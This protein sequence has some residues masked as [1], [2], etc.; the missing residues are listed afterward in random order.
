[1]QFLLKL[2]KALNSAQTPWQVTFAIT[3]GMVVGLTPLSGIQTVVIFFLAF[4]LNIHLGLF[5]ASSAFFA[6]IGY[7]FDPIFE[8]IGYA[9]LTSQ[10]LNGWWTAWYNNG[11]MRLSYFNSTLVLG[12][13][14]IALLAAAPLYFLLGWSINHYREALGSV[15]SKFPKLGLF[16]ILQASGK[17]DPLLRWWGAGVFAG[18]AAVLIAFAIFLADPLAKWALE[19]GASQLLQRDVRIGSVDIRFTEGAVDINRLE[20]AGS[21]EGFDAVSMEHIGFDI[22]LNALLFNRTHIEKAAINGMGFHTKATLKKS[23]PKKDEDVPAGKSEEKSD[24]AFSMPALELPDPKQVLANANLK[25]VKVYEKAQAEVTRIRAK[26]DDVAKN[27]FSD[28][29]L[30]ELENDYKALKRKASSNDPGQ[31][32][33]LKDDLKAFER[34]LKKREK[35]IKSIE[36]EFNTDQKRVGSLLAAIKNAP[37]N[38]FNKLKSTYSLD[39]KGAM[40]LVATLLGEKVKGYMAMAEKYYSMLAPYLKSEA[41]PEE[42]LPPR[43]QGRWIKFAMKVLNPDLLI[44][45]TEIDGILDEQKFSATISNITDRQKELGRPITFEASSDG[46]NIRGLKISGEDNR[47]GKGVIDRLSFSAKKLPLDEMVVSSMTLSNTAL[48]FNGDLVIS[49]AKTMNGRT[50]LRFRDADIKIDNLKGKTAKVVSDV[51]KSIN[52]FNADVTL[53]GE[54]DSPKVSVKTDLDKKLSSALSVG[55]KKQ[56]ARYEKELKGLL[57]SQMRERLASFN[58]EAAN[59]VDIN[60]LAGSQSSALGNLGSN[61]SGLITGGALKKLLKF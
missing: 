25:S 19:G 11:L 15:L 3:L 55:L 49:D 22:D 33:Q 58:D 56:A 44:K 31:L 59:I 54:L 17:K 37:K 39:D 32:L 46:R 18:V 38:D 10:G 53:G 13:T 2:F 60:T 28:K 51:L 20:V 6:G 9:L 16:G 26:W 42:K 27:E 4:L 36:K 14:V 29:A 48:G 34:K 12:S 43:G 45:K 57:D 35:Q 21:K 50:N 23:V 1:M 7:L 52:R 40:N 30:K 24:D 8:R 61:A 47:L 41:K 5:L